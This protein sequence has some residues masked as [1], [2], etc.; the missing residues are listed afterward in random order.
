M[1]SKDAT[2]DIALPVVFTAADDMGFQLL[3]L[4]DYA[5]NG[6]WDK[7]VAID[8]IKEYGAKDTYF[9]KDGD[10]FVSAFEG[11]NNAD[12]WKDIK[13]TNCCFI[14]DWSSVGAQ[15]AINLG[16]GIADGLFSWDAWPKGPANMTSYP[17][18][19][20]YVSRT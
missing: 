13:E 8:M 5:G 16:D 11:P 18:A 20:Y 17:D 15:P 12:D 1:A 7:A 4:F 9:K 10:P 2:N 19:S 6:P 3:F 14:P